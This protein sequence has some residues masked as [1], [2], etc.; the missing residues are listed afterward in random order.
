MLVPRRAQPIPSKIGARLI[1]EVPP[2]RRESPELPESEE[3]L[4]EQPRGGQ[5]NA[6][7][8]PAAKKAGKQREQPLL[9][10]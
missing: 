2:V 7:S 1:G 3:H 10:Q 4:P 8:R 5:R 6:D 9:N